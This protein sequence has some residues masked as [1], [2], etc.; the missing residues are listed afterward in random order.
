MNLETDFESVNEHCSTIKFNWSSL[1]S[2]VLW[3]LSLQFHSFKNKLL[4]WD[5]EW[6]SNWQDG[7]D[8][9]YFYVKEFTER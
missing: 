6:D 9:D 3:R 5:L 7:H 2:K 1:N 4:M 8:L